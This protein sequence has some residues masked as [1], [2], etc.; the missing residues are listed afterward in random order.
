MPNKEQYSEFSRLLGLLAETIEGVDKKIDERIKRIR[1]VYL[2]IISVLII[3]AVGLGVTQVTAIA[4]N[5]HRSNKNTEN[6]RQTITV[7]FFI[8]SQQLTR[9]QIKGLTEFY[10]K[11]YS[12]GSEGLMEAVREY[13]D[14]FYELEEALIVSRGL[15]ITPRGGK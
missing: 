4:N 12:E 13:N 8:T 2:G 1:N 11:Y 9:L 10:E 7:D 3:V 14:K 15:G 5:T 6:I